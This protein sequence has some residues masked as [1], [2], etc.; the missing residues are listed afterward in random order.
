MDGGLP[1]GV[2][3]LR[4]GTSRIVAV[5]EVLHVLAFRLDTKGCD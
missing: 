5:A 2:L 4:V 3:Q 1:V